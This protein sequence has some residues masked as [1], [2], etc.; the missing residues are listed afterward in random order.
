MEFNA[1]FSYNFFLN[2]ITGTAPV[3]VLTSQSTDKLR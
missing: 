2:T 1:A 3:I